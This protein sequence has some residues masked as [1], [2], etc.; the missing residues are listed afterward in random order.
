MGNDLI[1]YIAKIGIFALSCKP[2]MKTPKY[3]KY[4]GYHSGTDVHLQAFVLSIYMVINFIA[5]YGVVYVTRYM[6]EHYSSTDL[7]FCEQILQAPSKGT[8]MGCP[9]HMNQY[10]S[11]SEL[12]LVLSGDIEMN[13]GPITGVNDDNV[14][15][16]P[17][18][19][20]TKQ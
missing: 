10:S 17:Q 20:Q 1:D 15:K 12:L 19:D 3:G 5:F 4:S 2:K 18:R 13:P 14:K 11:Y 9:L 8:I 6:E 7:K 16:N